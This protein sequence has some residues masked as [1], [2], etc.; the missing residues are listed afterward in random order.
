M[1]PRL[2]VVLSRFPFPLDKGDKLRAFYFIKH[3]SLSRTIYL[4]ALSDEGSKTDALPVLQPYC[5]EIHVLPLSKPIIFFNLLTGFFNS[6]PFQV[7]YFSHN[8]HLETIHSAIQ[9]IKPE[10]IFIQLPRVAEYVRNVQGIHKT[11][12]YQDCFS[13]IMESRAKSGSWPLKWVYAW[14]ADRLKKYEAAIFADF[15]QH[16]II[17]PS[18]LEAM[19]L[20]ENQ[21]SKVKISPN[22]VELEHYSPLDSPKEFDVFFAGNM[23]YPPNV[24]A[25]V[26]LVEEVMPLVWKK[27]P[28]VKVALIGTTPHFRVKNLASE[29]VIVTGFVE[30]VRT[31]YGKGRMLVAPMLIGAGLQNK[32]LQAMSMEIPCITTPLANAALGG[33]EGTQVLIGKTAEELAHHILYLLNNKE[34]ALKIAQEG[35]A[36]VSKTFSWDEAVSAV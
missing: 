2:L 12:D 27:H 19:P 16:I 32:L 28:Q 20:S 13:K 3:L 18:D 4:F 34:S 6:L 36:F 23:S 15:Q 14:E 24:E 22:G 29:K 25:S 9:R 5:E 21:K 26:Y 35:R 10:G 11:I 30:D 17:S 33:K 31:W 1:K 8:K 7:N